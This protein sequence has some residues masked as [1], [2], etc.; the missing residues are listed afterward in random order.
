MSTQLKTVI[1]YTQRFKI[2]HTL[3][4]MMWLY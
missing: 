2:V 4:L 3:F 1:I